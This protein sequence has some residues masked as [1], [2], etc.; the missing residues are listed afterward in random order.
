MVR[1][2]PVSMSFVLSASAVWTQ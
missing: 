1:L 2:D